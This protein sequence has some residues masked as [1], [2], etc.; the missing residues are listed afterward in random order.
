MIF[1]LGALYLKKGTAT[2]TEERCYATIIMGWSLEPYVLEN[3]IFVFAGGLGR[4]PTSGAPVLQDIGNCLTLGTESF[5][6]SQTHHMPA[7]WPKKRLQPVKTYPNCRKILNDSTERRILSTTL[8][9][10]SGFRWTQDFFCKRLNTSYGCQNIWCTV[11]KDY[12]MHGPLSFPES[13]AA[14]TKFSV[15][16]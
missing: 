16:S 12:R 14:F 2:A 3:S 4:T 15:I 7:Q 1:N 8:A 5:A 11:I 10:Y 9:T 13:N 6:A